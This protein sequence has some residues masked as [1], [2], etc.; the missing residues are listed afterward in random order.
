MFKSR[1]VLRFLAIVVVFVLVLGACGDDD[2]NDGSSTTDDGNGSDVAFD[3]EGVLQ[4]GDG[5]SSAAGGV[6][7]DPI[8]PAAYSNWRY[9]KAIYGSLLHRNPDGSYSPE[10]ATAWSVVDPQ[11]VELELREGVTFTDGTPFNASAVQFNILRGRDAAAEGGFSFSDEL[12]YVEDVEIVD[13]YTV[14]IHVSEPVAGWMFSAGRAFFSS[15]ETLMPSPAAIEKGIEENP[16]GA[17]PFMFVSY[18]PDEEL[19]LSKNDTYWDADNVK[20]GGVRFVYLVAGSATVVG[21]RSGDIDIA[22]L[23]STSLSEVQSVTGLHVDSK[24]TGGQFWAFYMC[25]NIEPFDNETVRQAVSYAIDREGLANVVFKGAVTAATGVL[26]EGHT[27]HDPDLEGYYTRDTDKAKELLAEAGVTNLTFDVMYGAGSPPGE[28]IGNVIQSQLA[29]VGITMN[30]VPVQ[31]VVRE[32]FF[33][34]GV[35]A[36]VLTP[37]NDYGITDLTPGGIGNACAYDDAELNAMVADIKAAEPDSQAQ[38]DLID[39]YQKYILDHALIDW[40]VWDAETFAWQE[41]RVGGDDFY[42]LGKWPG[43]REIQYDKLFIK[44]S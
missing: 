3:P 2:T 1:G 14:R 12:K 18:R 24:V 16:V 37:G 42:M 7:F 22:N 41:D 28:D 29:E 39:Q 27:F 6:S 38:H 11:T 32:F 26:P 31:N 35:A 20:L 15:V 5:L 36:G 23:P 34:P 21:L 10:L 33:A 9:M 25:K 44:A 30:L 40:L 4:V 13:D 43:P 17:G 19:V 8:G